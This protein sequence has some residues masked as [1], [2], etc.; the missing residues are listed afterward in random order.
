MRA[1]DISQILFLND[2]PDYRMLM[3][4]DPVFECPYTVKEEGALYHGYMDML[5][6]DE[7]HIHILDFKTDRAFDMDTLK[8]TYRKQLETYQR[9]MQ[10]IQPDK[11]I[12]LW[13]A[14]FHLKEISEF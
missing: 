8:E 14:S 12:H 3:A 1:E 10:A 7:D 2:N 6:Q 5:C 4:M 9:A 11:K 13:L